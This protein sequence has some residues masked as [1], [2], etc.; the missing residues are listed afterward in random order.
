[1]D[2]IRR[3]NAYVQAFLDMEAAGKLSRTDASLYAA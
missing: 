1:M 3:R 2:V